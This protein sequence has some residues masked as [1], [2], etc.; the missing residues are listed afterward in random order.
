MTLVE[1]SFSVP[2]PD[3]H[4]AWTVDNSCYG[5][6][7]TC[8]LLSTRN[9]KFV[10]KRHWFTMFIAAVCVMFLIK[11][12]WLKKNSLFD[13]NIFLPCDRHQTRPPR[14]NFDAMFRI[15]PDNEMVT[16]SSWPVHILK[17]ATCLES[18]RHPQQSVLTFFSGQPPQRGPWERGCCLSG[19]SVLVVPQ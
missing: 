6:F 8:M 18:V 11:L 12:R 15:S 9:V 10:T 16:N 3:Q 5:C 2:H 13:A 14:Q 4:L 1:A 17:S 7:W 19:S